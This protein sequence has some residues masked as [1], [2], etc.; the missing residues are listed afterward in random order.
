MKALLVDVG[1]IL[2]PDIWEKLFL[3]PADGLLRT[4]TPDRIEAI[5][6]LQELFDRYAVLGSDETAGPEELERSYWEEARQRLSLPWDT[7]RLIERS[8]RII[9]PFPDVE[10]LLLEKIRE[11]FPIGICS[12][13]TAFW[14][15]RQMEVS[16]FLRCMPPARRIVSCRYGKTK[17]SDAPSLFHAAAAA[18]DCAPKE[19]LYLDDR[20]MNLERGARFGFETQRFCGFEAGAP[21]KL[22]KL[23]SR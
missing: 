5:H 23:L 19:I 1:G 20:S 21:E 18:L 6:F 3:D 12:N 14:F 8:I 2:F 7:D 15:C 13:Q 11:P 10:R 9:E 4:D 22:K 16:D 17:E